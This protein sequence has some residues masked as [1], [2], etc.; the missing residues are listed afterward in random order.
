VRLNAEQ[1]R[2]WNSIK[3]DVLQEILRAKFDSD[4]EA[5]QV[6]RL[7]GD[8]ELWHGARGIPAARQLDLEAIRD[9]KKL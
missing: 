4:D 5:A 7:T 3:H 6:L 8:A 1:L 2:L 9:V